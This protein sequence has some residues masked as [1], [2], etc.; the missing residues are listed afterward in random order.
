MADAVIFAS[1]HEGFGMPIIEGQAS[2][3][4]VLTSA[5]S[6]MKEIANGSCPLC[7]P[8][9]VSSIKTGVYELIKNHVTYERLGLSNAQRFTPSIIAREYLKVYESFEA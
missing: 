8:F 4:S 2:G 5:I 6:P 7:N 1:L 9:D 3:K